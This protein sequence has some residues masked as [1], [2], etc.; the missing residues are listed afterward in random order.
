MRRK[1]DFRAHQKVVLPNGKTIHISF[2]HHPGAVIIAPLINEDTV[3]MLR[4]FRP[5]LGRY[6]YELPAGTIDLPEKPLTCAKRELLEET[7]FSAKKFKKL[8]EIYPVPGYSTEVIHIFKAEGLTAGG[9][10]PEDYEVIDVKQFSR[11]ETKRLFQQGKLMDA[12][13]ICAF[14]HL[15]WI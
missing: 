1:L 4:Q 13:S 14:T 10:Q 9:A 15:G 7:G 3:V 11:T 8:G 12:K 2:I 5:A 6:I